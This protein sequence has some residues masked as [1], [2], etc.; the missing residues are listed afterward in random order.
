MPTFVGFAHGEK[1]CRFL[2]DEENI[3]SVAGVR[4]T[5]L[6]PICEV[7]LSYAHVVEEENRNEKKPHDQQIMELEEKESKTKDV[8]EKISPIVEDQKKGGKREIVK[9]LLL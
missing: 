1:W 7:A 4:F 2:Y 6:G 9:C 8:P 5:N 3:I